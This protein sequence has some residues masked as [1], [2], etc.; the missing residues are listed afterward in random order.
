M[1]KIRKCAVCGKYTMQ[2]I[3]CGSQTKSAHP[4][5]FT[6]EDKYARFRREGLAEAK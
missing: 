3:H 2:E 1:K 4:P 5:K 6:M